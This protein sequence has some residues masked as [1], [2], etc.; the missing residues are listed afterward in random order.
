ML[1]RGLQQFLEI[2]TL[3]KNGFSE[4]TYGRTRFIMEL[5][6]CASFITEDDHSKVISKASA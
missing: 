6:I 2:L 5:A 3:N 1:S 4:S